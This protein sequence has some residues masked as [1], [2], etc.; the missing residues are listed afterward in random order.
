MSAPMTDNTRGALYMAGAMTAFTVN[1]ACMKAL[2]GEVPLFQVIFLRG[3]L[4]T[5]LIGGF[6]LLRS[7]A[8]LRLPKQELRIVLLR[9]GAEAFAAVFFF[10]A[11]FNM[12]I[13]NV[14]AILQV[15]PLTVTFAAWMFLSEQIGW[16]RFAAILAGFVGVLII[17]R[18]DADGFSIHAGYALLAVLGATVRD[19]L[20]RKLNPQTSSLAV[21]LFTSGG[22]T[23]M[24]GMAS[25]FVPWVP[26]TASSAGLIGVASFIILA[27]YLLIVLAMRKGELS[28]VAPFRYTSLLVAIIIGMVVFDEFPD[29]ITYAGAVVVVGSGL[30]TLHRE[31][32]A[33]AA[34]TLRPR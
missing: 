29:L 5:L 9:S 23:L 6:L 21:T 7:P 15:L 3:V 11:L 34:R 32:W 4:T 30:Y 19:V 8:L 1:D 10:A 17:V 16:R 27:A 33:K 31:R 24:A 22:V 2:A 26:L 14:S 28:F 18:P 25:L 12:P 13:A 20:T